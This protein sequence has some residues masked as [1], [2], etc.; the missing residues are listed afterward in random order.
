MPLTLTQMVDRTRLRLQG[1]T[2]NQ[3]S[4]TVLTGA[5]GASDLALPVHDASTITTGM[6][7]LG[8][9]LVWVDSIDPDSNTVNVITSGRGWG[10]TSAAAH[11]AGQ[12]IVN[13]PRFPRAVVKEAID[14]VMAALYPT[15]FQVKV[16]SFTWSASQ[17]TYLL[18]EE[19]SLVLAVRWESVGASK[20]QVEVRRWT[21][22][23]MF[24]DPHTQTRA[25]GIQISDSITTGQK[26]HVF[27][28]AE[29]GTFTSVWSDTGLPDA[30]QDVVMWGAASNLVGFLEPGYL[31][32]H[33]VEASMLAQ[34]I[35][36]GSSTNA[37]RFLTQMYLKRLEEERNALL[38]AWPVR[39]HRLR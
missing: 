34:Q 13:N 3:D 19:T 16:H 4:L 26:V 9:E 29:P 1:L 22:D 36:A 23:N 6:A 33:S 18:P 17:S 31:D 30:V 14:V 37:A 38:A 2:T 24:V 21:A 27:Y 32:N 7:E 39:I 11:P 8:E 10:S 20:E 15:L 28:A 25:T 5:V 35:P 12:I